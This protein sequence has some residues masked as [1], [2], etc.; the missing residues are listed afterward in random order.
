[1]DEFPFLEEFLS[2]APLTLARFGRW[3]AIQGLP[4]PDPSRPYLVGID[5][6]VRGLAAVRAGRSDE[7]ARRLDALRGVAATEA[8][9]GLLLAGGT[10][11]AAE[12]LAIGEAHLEG[13]L[14]AAQ[15]ETDAAVEALERGVARQDRLVYM[16]PPP[17]YAPVR[18]SLGAVLL[19]AGRAAEAE[20]V[21][22]ADLAAYPKNGWSLFGL[23]ESLRA[24]DKAAEAD[25]ARQGF[26][27]AWT[28][29]DVTLE[30]SRF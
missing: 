10:A 6:Y 9:R 12:L 29:A 14:H 27:A 11:S 22:R 15:G 18:Q 3:D 28:Q 2:I 8:A 4:A 16:E 20:A 19:D 25:W 7:A 23:A 30:A 5:H 26:R 21:Y 13:E 17:W 1:V 24:Q